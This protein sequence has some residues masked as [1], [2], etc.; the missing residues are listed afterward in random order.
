MR[1]TKKGVCNTG[2]LVA[3]FALFVSLAGR[4]A[5][6]QPPF[7][8]IPDMIGYHGYFTSTIIGNLIDFY[9]TNDFALASGVTTIAGIPIQTNWEEDQR[10]QK[11]EAFLGGPSYIYTASNLTSVAYYTFGSHYTVTDP[12]ELKSMVA[13]SRSHAIGAQNGANGVIS[14]SI[15]LIANFGFDKTRPEHSAQFTRPIQ[16]CLPYYRQVLTSFQILP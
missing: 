11:P 7:P 12:Q 5:S 14:S 10:T 8:V 2:I 16:T 1:L 6:A 9:N 4:N 3:C 13:R 15:D